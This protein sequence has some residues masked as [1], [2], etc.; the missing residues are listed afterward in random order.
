MLLVSGTDK[1]KFTLQRNA[2]RQS[3]NAN[4]KRKML[5]YK[6]YHPIY[7]PIW[8]KT[9]ILKVNYLSNYCWKKKQKKLTFHYFRPT[10]I[11][12]SF[13]LSFFLHRIRRALWCY[14][15]LWWCSLITYCKV[16]LSVNFLKDRDPVNFLVGEELEEHHGKEE[17]DKKEE[18]KDRQN[19]RKS[20]ER[21]KWWNF[22]INWSISC[23]LRY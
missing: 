12:V 7:H 2:K 6:R 10:Y 18:N 17:K 14:I 4:A 19:A 22:H 8:F 11:H 9:S 16:R 5:V 21:L 20:P 23:A 3:T 1:M 13:F 15:H